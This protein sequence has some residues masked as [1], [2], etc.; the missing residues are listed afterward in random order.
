MID[1]IKYRTSPL[2]PAYQYATKSPPIQKITVP[3]LIMLGAKDV[4]VLNQNG[5]I[6]Y[7]QLNRM[8]SRLNLSCSLMISH[9][10]NSTEAD[11][12]GVLN[13]LLWFQDNQF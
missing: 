4:R 5:L 6:L 11:K 9:V 7:K 13:S 10:L 2:S 12:W 3:T 1:V 8:E